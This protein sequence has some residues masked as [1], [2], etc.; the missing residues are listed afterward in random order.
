MRDH[1]ASAAAE[2]ARRAA[3]ERPQG[4]QRLRVTVRIRRAMAERVRA[5]RPA[6]DVLLPV[7]PMAGGEGMGL[8]S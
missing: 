5:L 2:V 6:H 4:E 3:G 8:P 1:L 7:R